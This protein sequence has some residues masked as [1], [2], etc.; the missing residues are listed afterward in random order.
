MHIYN[1]SMLHCDEVQNNMLDNKLIP[2]PSKK[3]KKKKPGL[4]KEQQK[5]N[6]IT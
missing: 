4:V 5:Q 3:E 6:N 2:A 1:Y